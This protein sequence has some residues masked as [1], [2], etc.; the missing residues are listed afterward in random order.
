MTGPPT[1]HVHAANAPYQRIATLATAHDIERSYLTRFDPGEAGFSISRADPQA[2]LTTI[3]LGNRI[4]IES[5]AMPPWVGVISSPSETLD[6]MIGIGCHGLASLLDGRE[7][8]QGGKYNTSTG[9]GLVLAAIIASANRGHHTGISVSATLPAGP[10]VVDFTLGG[11]SALAA[12]QDLQDRTGLEAW[13]DVSAQPSG[14][15]AVLRWGKRQGHDHSHDTHLYEGQHFSSLE[16]SLDLG[17]SKQALSVIGGTAA[18]ASR[19]A[20]RTIQDERQRRAVLPQRAP[21]LE[22]VLLDPTT[23][24]VSE[25]TRRGSRDL[26]RT[27]SSTEQMGADVNTQADWTKLYPGNYVTVH[28]RTTLGGDLA[29]VLRIMG[30]Q[31]SEAHGLNSLAMEVA[32]R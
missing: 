20:V 16:Y 27:L 15:V 31:P 30:C 10:A 29:R 3:S 6:G 18:V 11:Q 26:E 13:L 8:A 22:R 5:P 28:A 24:R 2:N 1:V 7:A 12:I 9:S 4:F 21:Y 25:L 14:I 32:L 23:E 17:A 19:T